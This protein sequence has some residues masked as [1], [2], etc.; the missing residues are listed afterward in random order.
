MKANILLLPAML[1]MVV[2]YSCTYSCDCD[3]TLKCSTLSAINIANDS[4]I[5]Q[6]VV[7]SDS[8]YDYTYNFEIDSFERRYYRDNV[9]KV[10]SKDSITYKEEIRMR[11]G[12]QKPF[13]EKGFQCGCA[14]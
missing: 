7:C 11:G 4:L 9:V 6:Q 10:V 2:F 12:K 8:G 5:A 13:I 1:L 14:K 3:K